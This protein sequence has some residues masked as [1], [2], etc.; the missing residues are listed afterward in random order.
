[1]VSLREMQRAFAAALRDSS[2]ACPVLPAGN[3][4]IYRKNSAIS[5]RSALESSFPVVRR[6]VGDDYFRQ[7][8][9]QYRA[10]FPSRSG[11]LHWIGRDFPAFLLE[12]L[13]GS[14]YAWLAD[15][16]RLEWSREKASIARVEPSVAAD[17]LG[18]FAPTQLEHLVFTLQ[19]SLS[20]VASDFPIFTIWAANQV[21]NAPPVDQ[22]LSGECGMVRARIDLLEVR[23]LEPRLFSYLSAL[24]AGAPLPDAI[25]SAGLDQAGLVSALG[26]VFTEGLVCAVRETGT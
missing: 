17:V 16:A 11:D 3:L 18:R 25:V 22:S 10:R 8:S 14:E 13:H 9:A 1:M 12:H 24:A 2:A 7:L 21:D 5:F 20:L 15:L 23:P 6:R 19:P 26:F 4:S